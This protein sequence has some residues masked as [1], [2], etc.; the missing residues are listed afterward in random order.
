MSRTAAALE[1]YLNSKGFATYT[2]PC[3]GRM[4]VVHLDGRKTAPG[5]SDDLWKGGDVASAVK[6]PRKPE[7]TAVGEGFDDFDNEDPFA[8]EGPTAEEIMQQV[9]AERHAGVS[10]MPA[11]AI[12][13]A[14]Q[15]HEEVSVKRRMPDTL[16][17]HL[18][19]LKG[20]MYLPVA[21]R[22]VWFRDAC[23][24][25]GLA[26]QIIEGGWE[27]N[28]VVIQATVFN[29]EGRLIS[30]GIGSCTM[31][32]FPAGFLEKAETTAVG[33]ALAMAGF[34]TQ[35][36]DEFYTDTTG[37]LADAPV[38]AA[39]SSRGYPQPVQAKSASAPA[40][41]PITSNVWEG[42]GQCPACHAPPGKRHG[43][44]CY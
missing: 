30:Q 15:P 28:Y 18:L 19:N 16:K 39:V 37:K 3:G 26:T 6:E 9:A 21:F 13:I 20:K 7:M 23:T 2:E 33:R 24:E 44:P 22:L 11:P 12:L 38:G 40:T 34:G 35:F 1:K 31:Q 36:A 4:S 10:G 8:D 42:P 29:S 27:A 14:P 25:W 5:W 17:P 43:R 41:A 32:E